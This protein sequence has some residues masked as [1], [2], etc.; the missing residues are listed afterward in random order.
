[1]ETAEEQ[2]REELQ[3]L[4]R[5]LTH[6]ITNRR[7]GQQPSFET[8]LRI[9]RSLRRLMGT[10]IF[11][12]PVMERLKEKLVQLG[13][14][15]A[16]TAFRTRWLSWGQL[17]QLADSLSETFAVS[18]LSAGIGSPSMGRSGNDGGADRPSIVRR[19]GLDFRSAQS[20][21]AARMNMR[22]EPCDANSRKHLASASDLKADVQAN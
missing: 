11:P 16:A 3:E 22:T 15:D 6:Q 7:Q 9:E 2:S 20:K 13:W 19:G 18:A 5:S 21:P 4:L 14:S 8:R 12:A 1:M 10:N 17:E